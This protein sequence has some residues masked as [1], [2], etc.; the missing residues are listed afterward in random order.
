LKFNF[1]SAWKLEASYF[2]THDFMDNWTHWRLYSGGIHEGCDLSQHPGVRKVFR[3]TWPVSRV[4]S[5]WFIELC[6]R[7]RVDWYHNVTVNATNYASV[8]IFKVFYRNWAAAGRPA[9]IRTE[10]LPYTSLEL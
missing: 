6:C 9:E 4:I 5:S 8:V 10:Y 7:Y 3:S 1:W 2:I